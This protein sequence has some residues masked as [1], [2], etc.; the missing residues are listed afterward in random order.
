MVPFVNPQITAGVIAEKGT[1]ENNSRVA[2]FFQDENLS[3][4]VCNCSDELRTSIGFLHC[5]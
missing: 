1:A 2:F 4:S 5:V 3:P